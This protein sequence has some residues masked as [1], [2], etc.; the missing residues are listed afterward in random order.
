[1]H[2]TSTL[3]LQLHLMKKMLAKYV[4]QDK[5]HEAIMEG[6]AQTSFGFCTLRTFLIDVEQSG[7]LDQTD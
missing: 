3:A 6:F 2:I 5:S 1:M 4:K 7:L